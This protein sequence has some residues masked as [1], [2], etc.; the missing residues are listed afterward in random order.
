MIVKNLSKNFWNNI[1]VKWFL[2]Q[3]S[4]DEGFIDDNTPSSASSNMQ[5]ITEADDFVIGLNVWT[6]CLNSNH[7]QMYTWERFTGWL[8]F[9][10]FTAHDI[11]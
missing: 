3:T 1:E 5:T 8:L 11:F 7:Q 4:V 2:F 10:H 9:S 6:D